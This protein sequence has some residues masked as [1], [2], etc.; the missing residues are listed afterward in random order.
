MNIKKVIF[1]VA[2]LGLLTVICETGYA[3]PSTKDP[4]LLVDDGNG[5]KTE[6]YVLSPGET[7]LP[8]VSFSSS[9][10]GSGPLWVWWNWTYEETGETFQEQ[11]QQYMSF[12]DDPFTATDVPLV[13]WDS[14]TEKE[15]WW[16]VST[17]WQIGWTGDRESGDIIRF[18]VTSVVPEPASSALFLFGGAT[19]ALGKKRRKHICNKEN[20]S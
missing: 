2:I 5:N 7:P 13:G 20:K 3:Q 8:S 16:N 15:G 6:K 17:E 1:S 10:L 9:E 19:I 4:F 14:L 12:P 18:E 11:W